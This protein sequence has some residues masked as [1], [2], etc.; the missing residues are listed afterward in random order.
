MGALPRGSTSDP[1]DD[2]SGLAYYQRMISAELR[3]DKVNV[4]EESTE[5]VEGAHG[6][7]SLH[8]LWG[9]A[10]PSYSPYSPYNN[11]IRPLRIHLPP[12]SFGA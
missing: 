7:P 4:L 12:P 2:R 8:R 10:A 5:N 3:I 6:A 11:M 9:L 1:T